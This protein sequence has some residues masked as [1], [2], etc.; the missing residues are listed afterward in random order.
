VGWIQVVRVRVQGSLV[1]MG[2]ELQIVYM[3]KPEEP[4]E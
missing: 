3:G 4:V 1:N 2:I